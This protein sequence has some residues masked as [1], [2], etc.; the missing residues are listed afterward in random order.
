MGSLLSRL[1]LCAVLMHSSL[2]QASDST[3]N[4]LLIIVDDLAPV[5]SSYGGPVET[6]AMDSLAARG[7]RFTNNYANAP[8]CGA[9]RA[10][11]LS[12]LAPTA[13]RFLSYDSRLDQE[14]DGALSLPGYFRQK[15]FHTVANGKVFDVIDDSADSWSGSRQSR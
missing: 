13:T 11:L 14:V 5:I 8:V 1:T 15:G 12:G 4:V 2:V 9:S 7:V 6:P 3:L 10:S